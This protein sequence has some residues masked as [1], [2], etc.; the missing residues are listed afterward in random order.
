MKTR[1]I[2]A[3]AGVSLLGLLVKFGAASSES[4]RWQA[5][6]GSRSALTNAN[7]PGRLQYRWDEWKGDART[8]AAMLNYLLEAEP[9]EMND[10]LLASNH[11]RTTPASPD[12]A[13]PRLHGTTD[14]NRPAS[15]DHAVASPC[16]EGTLVASQS[17]PLPHPGPGKSHHCFPPAPS[18]VHLL[19]LHGFQVRLSRTFPSI[20]CTLPMLSPAQGCSQL[21]EHQ[22]TLNPTHF[23]VSSNS[24]L[25]R[26]FTGW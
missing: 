21:G 18:S 5:M 4:C 23:F 13:L 24:A 25:L 22:S 8:A 15:L 19:H 7:T 14:S 6:D 3:I 1:I 2:M 16:A 10:Q 20:P 12:V 9:P 26:R 11:G 17:K